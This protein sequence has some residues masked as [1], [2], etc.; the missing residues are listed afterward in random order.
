MRSFESR[1]K[2]VLFLIFSY[3]LVMIGYLFYLQIIKGAEYA[4]RVEMHSKERMVI[5]PK[6][7]MIFDR[8]GRVLSRTVPRKAKVYIEDSATVVDS[9][10]V[11][12]LYPYGKTGAQVLGYTGRDYNGLGGVEYR[13][14]EALTGEPG[15]IYGR[16]DGG[17]KRRLGK[18]RKGGRDVVDGSDIHLTLDIE[19]QEIVEQELAKTVEEFDANWAMAV[20]MNPHSGEIL[21][22]SSSANFNPNYWWKF[23]GVNKKSYPVAIN[24]E[25]GST[26][27]VL[28]LA[29]ALEEKLYAPGDSI[30]ANGGVFEI[31]DEVIRDH[32][33]RDTISIEDAL[34]YSSNVCFAKIADSLGKDRMYKY[35][36]DFGFGSPTGVTLPGEERG[37]LKDVSHWDGRTGVTIA[38][39]HAIS[40]TLMQMM[41]AFGAIANGG[42]LV[43][44]RIVSS[45]SGE[46]GEVAKEYNKSVVRSVISP[47]TSMS[48]RKM[49]RGVVEYGTAKKLETFGIPLAGKTGTSEKIDDSTGRYDRGRTQASFIGFAP[50]EKPVLLC[51]VVVDEPAGGKSGGQV[52][53]PAVA[54]ILN[55]ISLSP[56]LN[57]ANSFVER[58]DVD[59]GDENRAHKKYP[60]VISLTRK[61]AARVCGASKI[62]FEF[63]GDGGLIVH[64]SPDEGDEVIG[65]APL[66][67]YTDNVVNS[68]DNVV[69]MPNCVGRNMKDAINALSIKGIT[70]SF[71]GYG[72]VISQSPTAGTVMVP[73]QST[74]LF[75]REDMK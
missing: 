35:V 37:I 46:N 41:S 56:D 19:L 24:Y 47:E 30:D 11:N 74:T 55:R 69:V 15:W 45:I 48:V 26:F 70:P 51:G 38:F 50:V 40:T 71:K 8:K 43:T 13:F 14:N 63:V 32:V 25:P 9:V 57:M 59:R 66:L 58:S 5:T 16:R 29:A 64:Q 27:K 21:A 75:C 53:A 3:I 17:S 67:L 7:G 65:D 22:L 2:L 36:R 23:G 34:S 49:M 1:M 12:R 31:Y 62:K 42:Y 39:G 73:T 61:E 72:K 44:P 6:R 52:A 54:R 20:V 68:D 10:M 4:E 18:L 60:K 33:A 28:T